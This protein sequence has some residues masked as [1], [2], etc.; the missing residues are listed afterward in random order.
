MLVIDANVTVT[1]F[2]SNALSYCLGLVFKQENSIN[3][4]LQ[5]KTLEYSLIFSNLQS[6][7]PLYSVLFL[8]TICVCCCINNETEF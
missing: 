1:I 8:K 6:A 5:I 4:G 3:Q 2:I 7:W